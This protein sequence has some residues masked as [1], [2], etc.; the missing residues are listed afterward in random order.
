MLDRPG[1]RD[2]VC[3]S[4][5]T[6]FLE[7]EGAGRNAWQ[8][9]ERPGSLKQQCLFPCVSRITRI[10]AAVRTWVAGNQSGTPSPLDQSTPGVRGNSQVRRTVSAPGCRKAGAPQ[11]Q[12]G[13]PVRSSRGLGRRP[14]PVAV[15]TGAAIARG[16]NHGPLEIESDIVLG[17]EANTAMHLDG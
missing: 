14:E 3:P 9:V 12:Y 10:R 2:L 1:V 6:G 16:E 11:S 8:Q 5:L 15:L 17:S 13:R 7:E 4:N